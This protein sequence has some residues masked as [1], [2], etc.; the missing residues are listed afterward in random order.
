MMA[1]N[2]IF[3]SPYITSFTFSTDVDS[4]QLNVLIRPAAT[5][6]MS[7]LLSNVHVEM[8]VKA[9]NPFGTL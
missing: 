7:S 2:V 4:E 3:W 9:K 8:S 6:S 1:S 5:I